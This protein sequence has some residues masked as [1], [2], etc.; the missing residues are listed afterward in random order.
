MLGGAYRERWND[1]WIEY[2]AMTG[3]F[4][5]AGYTHVDEIGRGGGRFFTV[6]LERRWTEG[7]TP[8]FELEGGRPVWVALELYRLMRE[9]GT[10]EFAV[11]PLVAELAGSFARE[12]EEA[13]RPRWLGRVEERLRDDFIDPPPLT[14]LARDAGVHPVHL[15]RTFRRHMGVSIGEAVW[16]L[17]ARHAAATALEIPLAEAAVSAGFADQAHLTRVFR[18]VTGR[19][20]GEVRRLLR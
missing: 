16:R 15:S 12:R 20:P 18:R 5:P 11:E 14:E 4:H 3:V 19:T 9:G 13:A 1:R 17:K 7:A 8:R 10:A 6:E 2:A